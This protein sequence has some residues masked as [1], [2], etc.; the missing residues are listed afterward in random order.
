MVNL[1]DPSVLEKIISIRNSGPAETPQHDV[2]QS[3]SL[4]HATIDDA[5]TGILLPVVKLGPKTNTEGVPG[6]TP[7]STEYHLHFALKDDARSR[8]QALCYESLRNAFVKNEGSM[9]QFVSRAF[10]MAPSDDID[11]VWKVFKSMARVSWEDDGSFLV[12][13]RSTKR[14][15]RPLCV[16]SAE[17]VDH[18]GKL[19]VASASVVRIDIRIVTW[20]FKDMFG[21]S[22]KLGVGGVTVYHASAMPIVRSRFLPGNCYLCVR[23]S[24]EFEIR[25]ACGHTMRV[26]L[27]N[28]YD[29]GRLL[30]DTE[31]DQEVKE[32]DSKVGCP[33]TCIDGG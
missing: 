22:I 15:P 14:S 33:L 11:S 16:R 3:P 21:T 27:P 13:H 31:F 4:E 28:R 29:D 24:G 10:D 8:L 1:S 6:Y 30:I 25:D 18:S 9:Q 23:P 12:K 32:L 2:L 20:A 7:G 26:K 19:T 17:G 5:D